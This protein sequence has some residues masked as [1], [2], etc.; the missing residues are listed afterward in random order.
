MVCRVEG[1]TPV[2]GKFFADFF[3]SGIDARMIYLLENS[4]DYYVTVRGPPSVTN[5]DPYQPSS[6]VSFTVPVA[7]DGLSI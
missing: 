6:Y 5:Y 3:F 7:L 2:R 1:S 4:N